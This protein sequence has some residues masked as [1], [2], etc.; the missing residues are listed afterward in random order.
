MKNSIL[1]R[2]FILPV[3]LIFLAGQA[4]SADL[5]VRVFERGGVTPLAGVAVCVGT[6]AK[7]EQFGTMT[8]DAAGLVRF[9]SLPR[10]TLVVTASTSGFK[11]E[12][13]QLVMSSADRMLVLTLAS[14]GGGPSCMDAN[15]GHSVSSGGPSVKKFLI[16]GGAAASDR[17]EVVLNSSVSGKVTQFRASE[18]KDFSD[19]KWQDYS[20]TAR[21]ALSPGKG[22]KLVYFQVRRHS[23]MG[24]AVVESQ[25]PVVSDAITVTR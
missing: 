4:R 8:T 22:K 17:H 1:V 16:N 2:V 5:Q 24:E 6:Q 20:A 25:S 10:A 15:Q 9:E 19:A 23:A 14:G 18:H 7:P 12:Q 3:L 11:S 13:Q 21:Y